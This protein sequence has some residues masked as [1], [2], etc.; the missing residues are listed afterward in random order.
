M[1]YP[2]EQPDT[3][4]WPDMNYLL[5]EAAQARYA[6]A[7]FHLR[8]CDRILEIGGFKTPITAY[9]GA[10]AREVLVL[11]PKIEDFDSRELHGRPCRVRH[12]RCRYQDFDYAGLEPG[13]G[14]VLLGYSVKYFSD[15]PERREREWDCLVGL[16]GNARR[17]VIEYA[18]DW[19]LGADSVR[20]LL[21]ACGKRIRVDLRLDLGASPGVETE[22]GARRYLVVE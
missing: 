6:M 16:V 18:V 3:R 4:T 20:D 10:A 9:L 22:H 8:D 19:P 15:D 17:A 7:A 14:F 2:W 11:D 12:R 21:A 5:S 1:P 13:Y